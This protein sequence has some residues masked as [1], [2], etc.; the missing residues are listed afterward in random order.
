MQTPPK[1]AAGPT[2]PPAVSSNRT[3]STTP[4][5]VRMYIK[6]GVMLGGRKV[7]C[8]EG[9]FE[10]CYLLTQAIA[11]AKRRSLTQKINSPLEKLFL[12]RECW[13]RLLFWYESRY[14]SG[15][16]AYFSCSVPTSWS[17]KASSRRQGI[18]RNRET[19]NTQDG[20]KSPYC[21]FTVESVGNLPFPSILQTHTAKPIIATF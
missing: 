6:S 20:N 8:C 14:R 11:L 15:L 2:G 17:Q 10:R 16:L 1:M 12:S 5:R 21:R 13:A 9:S 3:Y 18:P 7:D 4:R 19:P